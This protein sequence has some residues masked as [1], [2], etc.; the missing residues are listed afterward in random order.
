MRFGHAPLVSIALLLVLIAPAGALA[1]GEKGHAPPSGAQRKKALAILSEAEAAARIE[2]DAAAGYR[3]I[4]AD[5]LPDH[6]TGRFPNAGNPNS[7]RAQNYTMRVALAPKRN[8]A[9]APSRIQPFGIA[10]NGVLF[11]PGTAEFW[12]NDPRTGWIMEAI[13]G[14]RNLGLDRNN[15]H[16]QPDGTYHYHGIPVGLVEK[17]A[18]RETP[19]LLGYAADGFPIYGP[20][21]YAAAADAT[22][23]LRKLKPGWRLKTGS[24]GPGEPPGRHD[25][26][27][28]RDFEFAPGTGD[29]DE[30]NG[31]EGVTAEYPQGT[32]YYVLTETFPFIP[33][34]FAGTPDPSF[35]IKGPP[36]GG[37]PGGRPGMGPPGMGPPGMGPPGMGAPPGGAGFGRPP[38]PPP[39]R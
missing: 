26:S 18:R 35:S 22:S 2:I 15:A 3:Y 30:C 27:Y 16:V 13:G 38:G 9:F 25:G 17:L 20:F 36:G 6:E 8:A 29:L 5:G 24:R 39:L 12:N 1:H 10:I 33:R 34:C 11:D 28:T 4:R 31:R 21:G 37:G 19:A 32:Y 23:G 14:P 7:I